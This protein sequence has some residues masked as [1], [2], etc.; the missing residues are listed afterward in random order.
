MNADSILN[1]LGVS[2]EIIAEIK[3]FKEKYPVDDNLKYRIP[4]P[5]YIYYGED[6]WNKALAALLSGN[7]ILLTGPKA[8]GKNVLSEC[9]SF[10]M[11]RPEWNVSFHINVDASYLIGTDTYNGAKVIF[12]PGPIHQCAVHGGFGVLDEINMAKNEALAVLH[13][14]LDFRK[15]IDVPGY[16]RIDMSEAT[17]F[18]G[19]MN[20]GY[21][22]T[23]D[24][25]EALVSRF[26]VIEMPIITEENLQKLIFSA[27]PDIKADICNQLIALFYELNRKAEHSDISESAVDLRGILDSIKLVKN[28]LTMGEA[29]EMCIRNKC[30]DSYERKLIDDV[31]R[32]RIPY[33]L[34]KHHVFERN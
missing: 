8:T 13:S 32:A 27:H 34:N 31:I 33:E 20:Y 6:I 9:L 28:G 12:R 7:N 2:S 19:T 22:G 30:F 23:R 10:V 24:L 4:E 17:R 29:L 5:E 3:N 16:E 26:A 11:G 15:I 21:A 14:A 1:E 25:N 18:I